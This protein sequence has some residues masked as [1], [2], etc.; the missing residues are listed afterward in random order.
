MVNI[1][2]IGDDEF[3]VFADTFRF[4]LE[5]A[6]FTTNV[7]PFSAVTS[8]WDDTVCTGQIETQLKALSF[9]NLLTNGEPIEV[10]VL[11]G[12]LCM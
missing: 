11:G 12:R 7:Q 6:L 5:P 8:A 10:D 3:D 1:E 4:Y 9:S 2:S